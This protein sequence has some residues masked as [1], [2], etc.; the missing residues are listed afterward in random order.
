ME[1]AVVAWLPSH[2][3]LLIEGAAAHWQSGS[4]VWLPGHPLAFFHQP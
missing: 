1:L 2:S 4:T 3:F